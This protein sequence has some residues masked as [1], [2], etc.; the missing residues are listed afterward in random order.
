VL[1]SLP[2]AEQAAARS[3]P[4]LLEMHGRLFDVACTARGCAHSVFDPSSPVCA[5]LAGTEALD[6]GA[7]RIAPEELPR[8]ARCGALARPGVV[9]FGERPLYLDTIDA[10]VAAAELC[11][12]VGTSSTVR[13][14]HGTARRALMRSR[15]TLRRAMRRKLRRAA[16]RSRC[17]TSSGARATRMR[18]FC[19]SGR[20]RRRCPRRWEC[21]R[22]YEAPAPRQLTEHDLGNVLFGVGQQE[23]SRPVVC[24]IVMVVFVG[25]YCTFITVQTSCQ[26]KGHSRTTKEGHLR[27]LRLRVPSVAIERIEVIGG[28]SI[29]EVVVW[30]LKVVVEAVVQI[31]AIDVVVGGLVQI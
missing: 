18:T 28:K 2:S 29:I 25:V 6:V 20:A 22:G 30:I 9:W 3:T 21:R 19:S 12:V 14:L 23:V 11:I 4:A 17:S 27:E 7:P 26:K 8:C 5:A 31:V 16:G 10:L 1:P 24:G 13:F 15:C